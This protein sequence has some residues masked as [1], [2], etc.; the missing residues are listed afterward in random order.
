MDLYHK[1]ADTQKCLHF[2]SSHPNHCKRNIPSCLAQRICTTAENNTEKLKNLETLKSNLWKYHYPD[3]LI[4]L[5]FQKALSIPQK[6]LWKPKPFQMKI[7]H[8][9]QYL[10]Q[11]TLTFIVLLRPWSIAWKTATSIFI[12][13]N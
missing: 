1:P 9:L 10:I 6:D 4:K 13:S 2:T 11:I 12:I 7:S 5:G 8:S 3:S